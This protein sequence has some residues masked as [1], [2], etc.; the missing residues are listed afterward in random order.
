MLTLPATFG[1]V[2]LMATHATTAARGI[3]P[4]FTQGDR[5]R[6]A[7][8][9]SGLHMRDLAAEIGVS[10]ASVSRYESGKQRPRRATV[11]T[12]A[13]A[14]GVDFDWLFDGDGSTEPPPQVGA[15]IRN[16]ISRPFI[17]AGEPHRR[18]TS[19]ASRPRTARLGG[20]TLAAA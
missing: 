7:R 20:L 4:Q 14:T 3:V 8:E 18:H 16:E 5:L 12:W 19:R 15:G 17:S 1:S 9:H 13:L 6:K 11:L 10:E 2:W